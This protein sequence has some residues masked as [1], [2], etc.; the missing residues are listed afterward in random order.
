MI[1]ALSE[2]K[3]SVWIQP[4]IDILPIGTPDRLGDIYTYEA[5][6]EAIKKWNEKTLPTKFTHTQ[7]DYVL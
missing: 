1:L 2:Y 5:I 3:K 4:G 7:D 6:E